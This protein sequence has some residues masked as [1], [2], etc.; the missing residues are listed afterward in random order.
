M[1]LDCMYTSSRNHQEF[2]ML[3]LLYFS[4]YKI[5]QRIPSLRYP[6]HDCVLDVFV[7]MITC[8]TISINRVYFE[9]V[10][11]FSY[12]VCLFTIGIPFVII[13]SMLVFLPKYCSQK[14]LQ[15]VDEITKQKSKTIRRIAVTLTLVLLCF[16]FYIGLIDWNS[17]L[18]C[19]V[20]GIERSI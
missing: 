1:N 17:N 19:W 18:L 8:I 16:L 15:F 3:R 7:F 12:K 11:E 2:I 13:L 4:I 10:E 6:P 9:F 14:T 20:L 5:L